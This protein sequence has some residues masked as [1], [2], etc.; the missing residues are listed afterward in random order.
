MA[1]L[2][3][4]GTSWMESMLASYPGFHKT[5]IPEAVSYEL[6]N[7]G[8]HDYE[9]P[10]DLPTRFEDSLTVL[11]LHVPGSVHNTRVLEKG[12]ISYLIMYRDLRD[13]AVSHVFY[14]QRTPWHPEHPE[15]TDLSV[16]EGLHHF[17]NTLLPEFVEWI[18]SWDTNR[19]PEQSLIVRYEDLLADTVATFREVAR[20]FELPDDA[21]TIESIVEAHRFENLSGGRDRGDDAGDSF[22]RK[23]VSGDW[24]NHFTPELKSLYKKT[25]GEALIDFGYE[26][27]LDW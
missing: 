21:D 19:D 6:E 18:R 11:K 2:P 3:K 13:V 16:R 17:G 20:L 9:L 22:F 8:T 4:S 5:M 27:D 15:Y 7:G 10:A 14:V 23:G 1:G 12:E 26:A 25:A 24:K